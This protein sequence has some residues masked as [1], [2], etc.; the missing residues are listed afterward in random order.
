MIAEITASALEIPQYALWMIAG[1]VLTTLIS[2]FC[3]YRWGLRSQKEAARLKARNDVLAIIER[4][5][6]D[7]ETN[8]NCWNPHSKIRG[9]LRSVTI[10]FYSQFGPRVRARIKKA[11]DDYHALYCGAWDW[12]KKGTPERE[13]FDREYKAQLDGL[14]HLRDE[15]SD[16]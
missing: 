11:L 5:F 3:G 4:I 16:T 6:A 10:Q 14:G 13:K 1:W 7:M 15:I 8:G 9:D 2:G 12:P